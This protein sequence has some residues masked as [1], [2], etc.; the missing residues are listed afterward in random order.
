MGHLTKLEKRLEILGNVLWT[1][2]RDDPRTGMWKQLASP[3]KN[4]LTNLMMFLKRSGG[5]TWLI[6]GA[7]T[8]ASNGDAH[9][10]FE[11]SV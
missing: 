9:I 8:R 7:E 1:I 6:G 5:E 3:Q 4:D 11:S 2:I 10:D